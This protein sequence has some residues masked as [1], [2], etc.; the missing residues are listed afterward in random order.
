MKT[1]AIR[2]VQV[3]FRVKKVKKVKEAERGRRRA[4]MGPMNRQRLRN[5]MLLSAS[6]NIIVF[7]VAAPLG[8]FVPYL[9][10]LVTRFGTPP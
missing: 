2:R 10:L 7:Q 5:P 8:F 3:R 1:W 9:L 6:S 4:K